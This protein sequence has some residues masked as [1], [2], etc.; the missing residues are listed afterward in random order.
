MNCKKICVLIII[1]AIFLAV[2]SNL[3]PETNKNE[4]IP[5][6]VEIELWYGLNG[7]SNQVMK[8]LV[9]EFNSSQ[10]KY[11]VTGVVYPSH[12]ETFKALKSAIARKKAPDVVLL[13]NQHLY[14]LAT[15]IG[16]AHV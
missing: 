11:Y 5:K 3:L 8:A 12:K 14:Y 15:K 6:P 7:Y 10:V 4:E 16:R 1:C 9:E 13:E 2:G